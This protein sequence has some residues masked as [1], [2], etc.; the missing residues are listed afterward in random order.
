LPMHKKTL[1]IFLNYSLF[2]YVILW[3]LVPYVRSYT[4]Q[5]IFRV[6]FFII[7]IMWFITSLLISRKW[8]NKVLFPSIGISIYILIILAYIIF[9]YGDLTLIGLVNPMLLVVYIYMG[10]FYF[11]T[12]SSSELKIFV[13][14]AIL[15]FALTSTTSILY[16]SSNINASRLLTSSSTSESVK[17]FLERNNVGS[18]DFIYGSVLLTPIIIKLFLTPFKKS[19]SLNYTKFLIFKLILTMI[20]ISI[21]VLIYMSNFSIS[22]ILLLASFLISFLPAKKTL[23]RTIFSSLLILVL[24]SPFIFYFLFY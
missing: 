3:T 4:N 9:D 14:I 18:F 23:S 5:G 20:I 2:I 21:V 19:S 1:L 17:V 16:L 24:T 12:F 13:I 6:L 10:Y 8:F 22:Y 15:S 11:T 7:I